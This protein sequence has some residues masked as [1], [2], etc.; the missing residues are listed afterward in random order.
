MSQDISPKIMELVKKLKALA[1]QGVGGE[2]ENAAVILDRYMHEYKITW[3][4]LN[5]EVRKEHT[6][7][8]KAEQAKFFSQ[9]AKHV[10]GQG[11]SIFYRTY[12]V[13]NK[14]VNQV[15]M[16]TCT[17]AEYI[18]ICSKLEFYWKKYQEDLDVFYRAFIHKNKLFSKPVDT[19]EE[20]EE[21]PLT[22]KEKAD[23]M[24]LISMM[25]GL[26]RHTFHKQLENGK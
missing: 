13:K 18:E 9:I 5:D 11:T 7:E 17:D 15:R 19:N 14:R 22:P 26:E 3:D 16:V 12:Q 2:K 6:F 20:E 25:D 4:M 1:E 21:K 24:R 10:V 23:L 8:I